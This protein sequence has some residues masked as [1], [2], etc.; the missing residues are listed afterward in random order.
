MG[1]D[2]SYLSNNHVSGVSTLT[3]VNANSFSVNDFIIVGLFG[4]PSA[5]LFRILSLNTTARTIT[6]GT[7]AGVATATKFPHS[8]SSRV[9]VIQFDHVEFYWTALL[10]TIADETPT[11]NINT[12]LSGSVAIDPA[13]WYTTYDD[14][15]HTTGFG[16]FVFH[17]S[18]TSE[19]SQWSNAIPYAGFATNSVQFIFNDFLS[20][21][22]NKEL[23]LVTNQDMFSWINEG[24]SLIRNK[25][26]LSNPEYTVS[27][28]Q[29][30]TLVSGTA[31][32]Q[33]ASDFGDL[34]QIVDSTSETAPAEFMSIK[35]A[36]SYTG[37]I[38]HY[39]VRGRYIGFVPT[40]DA[41]TLLASPTYSYRYRSKGSRFTDLD[42][43]VDL[44][45]NG[46]YVLKDWMMYRACLKFQNPNVQVYY[47][48]FNDGLNQ[49]IVSSISRDA[50]LDSWGIAAHANA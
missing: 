22:N 49:M 11:P 20:L 13:S 26:N 25:L 10:G 33:L 50:N 5:E 6:I 48:A 7:T 46:A 39:Y 40:P 32:Y 43:L 19:S 3:V 36:M 30:I 15:G 23:K 47:K 24:N 17:N 44:P 21:L 16:W 14:T 8:E 41:S 12:P 42:D 28:P 31:E 18:I 37:S 29:T 35:D 4:N 2:F 27:T 9:T 38:T 34:V 45:D 1:G